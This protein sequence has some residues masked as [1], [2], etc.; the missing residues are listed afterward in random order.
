MSTATVATRLAGFERRLK[1]LVKTRRPVDQD[2]RDKWDWFAPSCPCGVPIG[3]CALHPRARP[4]QRPPAGD[5]R[6]FVYM[7]GRGSG[8]TRA[9]ACWL[10][11]RVQRGLARSPL[12][13]GQTSA[14]TRDIMCRTILDVSPPWFRPKYQPSRRSIV[15]PNGAI[16]MTLSAEDPEQARGPNADACWCDELGAWTRAGETWRNVTLAVRHGAAQTFVSTTP[17]RIDCLKAILAAPTTVVSTESTLANRL[18]LSPEFVD[19]ILALYADTTF[20]ESEI[21]GRMVDIVEGVWFHKFLES[22]HVQPIDYLRGQPVF[23]SVDA[24]TSRTTAAI[25]FQT[26]RLDQF[27]VRFLCLDAYLE[28]DKF[29]AENAAAI[30]RQF[31]AR[32]PDVEP[33]HVYIDGSSGQRTSLGPTAFGEYQ[34]CFG[35]K[36]VIPVWD[37]NVCDSLDAIQGALER[38]DVI[39]HPRAVSLISAFKNFSR[40]SRGGQFLDVPAVSQSP[41]E[42][43][44]DALKYAVISILPPRKP[45]PIFHRIDA[46]KL[47]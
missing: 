15:W 21:Q 8:K 16:G 44:I 43:S 27:R 19:Q 38:G 1:A 46:R 6:T 26:Q 12:L 18:W 25:M 47:T 13:V 22:K 37:Q 40:Q 4:A 17:K 10:I 24:G 39:V 23:V 36:K 35:E 33:S 32:F 30:L 20:A 11:D 2:E 28:V 31:K 3:T 34:R 9:G 5:W 41:F 14:D 29:S 7:G 42:D 45:G